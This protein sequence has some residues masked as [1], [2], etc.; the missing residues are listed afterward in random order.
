MLE[1]IEFQKL[2]IEALE[3]ELQ[4]V[5]DLLYATAKEIE[6]IIYD[7]N[8]DKPISNLNQNYK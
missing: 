3:A 4:R 1:T 2:R 5:N 7:P 6:V 8:F